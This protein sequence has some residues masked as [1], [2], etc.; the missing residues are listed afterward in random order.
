M[1][2]Y[3]NVYF[4][5]RLIRSKIKK[6]FELAKRFFRSVKKWVKINLDEYNEAVSKLNDSDDF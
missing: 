1:L 6:L 5:V 2:N 3:G 4:V